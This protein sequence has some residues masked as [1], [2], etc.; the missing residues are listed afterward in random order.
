MKYSVT[1]NGKTYEVEVE[2]AQAML[3]NEYQ[4]A[5]PV[6]AAPDLVPAAAAQPAAPV[7]TAVLGNKTINSPLPGTILG[8]KVSTGQ[9]VTKGTV[10]F[11]VEAMKMENEVN[12]PHDGKV[13]QIFSSKGAQVST[14]TPILELL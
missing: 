12:A 11:I 8:I 2:E 14:G 5:V 9:I 1:L 3:L 6:V 13:G 7:P 10:L 4:A